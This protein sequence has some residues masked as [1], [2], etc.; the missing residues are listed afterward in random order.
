MGT[1][2]CAW[3]FAPSEWSAAASF[4][5]EHCNSSPCLYQVGHQGDHAPLS[6]SKLRCR[7][8]V[9]KYRLRLLPHVRTRLL[10][11]RSLRQLEA[12]APQ[13]PHR[14]ARPRQVAAPVQHTVQAQALA[15]NHEYQRAWPASR[16]QLGGAGLVG[17]PGQPG[18][19]CPGGASCRIGQ[20]GHHGVRSAA[21]PQPGHCAHQLHRGALLQRHRRRPAPCR[22]GWP[23][24][25]AT[26]AGYGPPT[27]GSACQG[28]RLRWRRDQWRP[29]VRAERGQQELLYQRAI[30]CHGCCCC[31][32]V[33]ERHDL[34]HLPAW[35]IRPAR[36]LVRHHVRDVTPPLLP[37]EATQALVDSVQAEH[38]PNV[39]FPQCTA[40]VGRPSL[41][42]NANTSLPIL[43]D[44]DGWYH[45]RYADVH[46]E[47]A[48]PPSARRRQL[49][50][51]VAL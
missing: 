28:W 11:R 8:C 3:R 7:L 18:Q 49:Y 22:G 48:L 37:L 33:Q 16:R 30:R 40:R 47:D 2:A 27:C 39:H 29:R 17:P 38:R 43:E 14:S 12:G 10:Q 31:R 45:L 5:K 21:V 50:T 41:H 32:R 36:H 51:P 42:L 46:L 9:G 4:H 6:R 1:G 35:D 15:L 44:V 19:P 13:R 25:K 23:R 20:R 34:L 24:G 26:A